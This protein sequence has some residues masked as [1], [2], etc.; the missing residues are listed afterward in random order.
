LIA[1]FNEAN[2]TVTET[3]DAEMAKITAGAGLP[4]MGLPF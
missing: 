1:A 2:K 4:G 3:N